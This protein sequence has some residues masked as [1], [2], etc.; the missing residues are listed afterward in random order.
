MKQLVKN[1]DYRYVRIRKGFMYWYINQKS[2]EAQNKM[3]LSKIDDVI[4]H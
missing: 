2:R 3:D 1:W 4:P